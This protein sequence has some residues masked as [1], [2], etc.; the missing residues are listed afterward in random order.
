[1]RELDWAAREARARHRPLH[2]VLA[3]SQAEAALPWDSA[4][5]RTIR[6][7]LR[8]AAERRLA[9]AVTYLD[10]HWPGVEHSCAAVQGAAAE[11]LVELSA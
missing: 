5:D 3:W 6:R 10:E 1:M 4:V 7:E 8:M 2:L 11:A 9:A